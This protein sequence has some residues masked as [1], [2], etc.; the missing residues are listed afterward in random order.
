M[1]AGLER[2]SAEHKGQQLAPS[3]CAGSCGTCQRQRQRRPR[4]TCFSF[5]ASAS[6]RAASRSAA[7]RS[8]S[9]ISCLSSVRSRSAAAIEPEYR[10]RMPTL[11]CSWECGGNTTGVGRVHATMPEQQACRRQRRCRAC[12][13]QPA[14]QCNTHAGTGAGASSGRRRRSMAVDAPRGSLR[15]APG[16]R[17]SRECI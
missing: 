4:R 15:G 5:T 6:L 1:R 3:P 12:Q 13:K 7:I 16:R 2:R 10:G 11:S 9:A 14:S 8:A 17:R